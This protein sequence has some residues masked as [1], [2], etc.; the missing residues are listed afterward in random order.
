M[1]AKITPKLVRSG[2]AYLRSLVSGQHSLPEISQQWLSGDDSVWF[3]AP[4]NRILGP[5]LNSDV[6]PS[7]FKILTNSLV[8]LN[9]Q[10][11]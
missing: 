1:L 6:S 2:G 9:K 5:I 7:N 3:G 10:L 11:V 4:W 8:L